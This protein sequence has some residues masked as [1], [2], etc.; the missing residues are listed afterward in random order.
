[1]AE[2]YKAHTL[3]EAQYPS[4][5]EVLARLVPE[6]EAKQWTENGVT[7]REITRESFKPDVLDLL[8]PDAK[9][10]EQSERV[11]QFLEELSDPERVHEP[12]TGS[13][14]NVYWLNRDFQKEGKGDEALLCFP[15]LGSGPFAKQWM[16]FLW[17]L[18]QRFSDNLVISVGNEGT[19]DVKVRDQWSKESPSLSRLSKARQYCIEETLSKYVEPPS[20]FKLVGQSMGGVMAHS[21]A[22]DMQKRIPESVDQLA[23]V[24]APVSEGN[25]AN[26]TINMIP[27][28][29][30]AL[31][32]SPF[33]E[34]SKFIGHAIRNVAPE[35]VG[36]RIIRS[37]PTYRKL[38]EIIADSNIRAGELK[39]GTDI[40]FIT[41]GKDKVARLDD[42]LKPKPD[43]ENTE[44]T[45]TPHNISGITVKNEKHGGL[46][47]NSALC[48]KIVEAAVKKQL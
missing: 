25:L 33:S 27:Q 26:L 8:K 43:T 9:G 16:E 20:K 28:E 40:S 34:Q 38:L 3:P 17:Q 23:M 5:G 12:V 29:T 13:E 46:L 6:S 35:F 24:S 36:R 37:I 32:K 15:P 42:F 18:S 41:G 22:R 7:Y 44:E 47:L 21:V 14:F 31:M 48:G 10:E 30:L 4:D 19:P 39:P 1:M 2:A 11:A 45:Y